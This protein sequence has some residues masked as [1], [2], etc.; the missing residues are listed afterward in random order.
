MGQREERAVASRREH[1]VE[2]KREQDLLPG[3][4]EPAALPHAGGRRDEDRLV[5]VVEHVKTRLRVLGIDREARERLE[6]NAVALRHSR[7]TLTLFIL[8]PGFDNACLAVTAA[9]LGRARCHLRV[10]GEV[11]FK[12]AIGDLMRFTHVDHRASL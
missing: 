10:T 8:H 3:V 7:C 6:A 11:D 12:I 5:L 9:L 2:G 4:K 1:I